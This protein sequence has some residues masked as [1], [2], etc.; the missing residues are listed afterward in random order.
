MLVRVGRGTYEEGSGIPE[1]GVDLE[2][3][4][5]VRIHTEQIWSKVALDRVLPA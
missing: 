5:I 2:R 3:R 1:V 4:A